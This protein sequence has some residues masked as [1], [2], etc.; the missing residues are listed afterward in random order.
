MQPQEIKKELKF[1]RDQASLIDPN[2]AKKIDE[3]NR[4]IKDIKGGALVNKKIVL[5]FLLQVV[6]DFKVILALKSLTNEADRQFNLDKMT[7]TEKYWY[8]DLFPKWLQ[9]NDPKFYIWKQKLMSGQFSQEDQEIIILLSQRIRNKGG[10]TF[11][12]YIV[13]LSMATDLIVSYNRDNP[14]CVQLTSLS[15]QYNKNK[16]QDWQNTLKYWGIDRGLFL[17]YNPSDE[18]FVTQLVNLATYNSDHLKS[19]TYLKFP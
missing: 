12:R 14:L 17:N 5:L 2:I 16:Y 18:N 15:D 3:I 11:Q 19:G 8:S 10:S 4:W 6:K 1:L 7:P 13:D 9:Q